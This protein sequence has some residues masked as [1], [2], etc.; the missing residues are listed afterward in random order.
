MN[1]LITAIK[2]GK[3]LKVK[4]ANVYLDGRFAFSLDDEI[5]VKRGLKPGLTLSTQEIEALTG[6]DR[7]QG[8]L[9]AGL[10]FLSYRPRSESEVRARLQRRGFLADEIEPTVAHL[11]E[12]HLLDDTA[13][14]EY[15]KE[16]RGTFRPR[17]QRMLKVELRRKGLGSDVINEALAGIDE[18]ENA[19]KAAAAKARTISTADYRVF[20]Q[21]LGGFLQRRG[22]N[23]SVVNQTLNRCWA[24]KTGGSAADE[25]S[26]SEPPESESPTIF[27]K[28]K[29]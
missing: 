14:A 16:N 13:F 19:Y 22:F 18:G 15:W 7:L 24:D 9:N 26:A 29:I 27:K 21:K 23:Y 1:G 10:Y 8:C 28:R 4:R 3:N 11:R 5:I 17:S 6:S 25:W 20:S 2:A 12:M